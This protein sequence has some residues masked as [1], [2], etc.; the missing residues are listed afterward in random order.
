M[1]ARSVPEAWRPS[2]RTEDGQRIVG[3]RGRELTSAVGEFSDVAIMLGDAAAT[4][5]GHL[6]LSPWINLVPVDAGPDE[7]RLVCRVQNEA[8]GPAGGR[9]PRAAQRGGRG[10]GAGPGPGRAGTGGPDGRAGPARRGDPV[11]RGRPLP[12]RRLLPP[13]LGGGRRDR[14]AGVHPPLHPGLR[15]PRPGRLL[16]VELGRQPAGNRGHRGAHRGGGGAGAIPGAADPARAR[17]RRAAGAARAAAPR[18]RDPGRGGGA[19]AARAP[20]CRCAGSTTTR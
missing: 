10:P 1:T 15:D 2:L 6:L 18:P 8:P 14:R 13:V 7:A 4:G 16:P 17:R 12:G 9:P 3:F 19:P 20:T 11:Q 5:I